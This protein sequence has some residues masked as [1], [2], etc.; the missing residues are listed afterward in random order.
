MKFSKYHGLGNDFLLLDF[1]KSD[2]RNV[3][4]KLPS[5]SWVIKVCTRKFGIGGDGV[6]FMLPPAADG[7]IA[8]RIFNSDGSE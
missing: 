4:D 2:E 6:I 5:S 8:M 3:V 7:D 1:N